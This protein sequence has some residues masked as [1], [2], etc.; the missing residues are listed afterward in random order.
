MNETQAH[1]IKQN[2]N[3]LCEFVN[4]KLYENILHMH[5]EC[6]HTR[7]WYDM[8]ELIRESMNFFFEIS[9]THPRV[10]RESQHLVMM[11]D[12]LTTTD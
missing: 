9:P 2:L 8:F 3:N 11:I 10:L 4:S 12:N 5:H 1:Q 7:E 6:E